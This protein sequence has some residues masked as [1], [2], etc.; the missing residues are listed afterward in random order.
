M[1][2]KCRIIIYT[3]FQLLGLGWWL[4][5]MVLGFALA[6]GG[7]H[8]AFTLIFFFGSMVNWL[9]CAAGLVAGLCVLCC[10]TPPGASPIEMSGLASG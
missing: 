3:V 1:H 5:G 10:S 2:N 8:E 7:F 6:W 4:F 9:T